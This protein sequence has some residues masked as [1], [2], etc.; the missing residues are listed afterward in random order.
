[1]KVL[2]PKK[3]V[4]R[5]VV[6]PGFIVALPLLLASI[7]AAQP[8]GDSPRGPHGRG[9]APG[10]PGHGPAHV[11]VRA[12]DADR[13]QLISAAE[14]LNAGTSLR[15]LDL[16]GDGAVTTDELRPARPAT[17]SANGAERPERP[18]R[19]ERPRPF[20]PLMLALDADEDGALSVT[21][22]AN[23]MASLQALD[24]N[25]DGQLTPDEFLPTPPEGARARK[26]P[27]SAKG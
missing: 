3:Y 18:D 22:I 20:N 9:H 25:G 23:A 24:L 27:R 12:L 5:P 17:V 19:A 6:L 10:G 1:M 13:D 11:I 15:T 2:T 7:A 14:L 8:A 21:E 26:G 4:R 16:N